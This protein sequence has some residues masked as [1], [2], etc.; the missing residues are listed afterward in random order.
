VEDLLVETG[1]DVSI[2]EDTEPAKDIVPDKIGLESPLE[3]VAGSVYKAVYLAEQIYGEMPAAEK[4]L[5]HVMKLQESKGGDSAHLVAVAHEINQLTRIHRAYLN[6]HSRVKRTVVLLTDETVRLAYHLAK[7]DGVKFVVYRYAA[8]TYAMLGCY[9]RAAA[10]VELAMKLNPNRKAA[11]ED[12]KKL[13]K[14]AG[15]PGLKVFVRGQ[16]PN[17]DVR[18]VIQNGR[19]LV[20]I[21]AISET[22]GAKVDFNAKQQMVIVNNG[23]INVNLYLNNKI[24][25]VN[26][27]KV[28]LDEPAKVINKRTMIP[29]RF[30]SENLG[31]AVE[32]DPQSQTITVE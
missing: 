26:G 1:E 16:R 5:A 9:K 21:R 23:N 19:T 20:P 18:P 32:Y 27:K 10:V 11:Y 15:I 14:K 28:V 24:A 13:Y 7:R 17:F 6:S 3:P 4:L 29:L 12:L 8:S 30:V 2:L 25:L 31:A 22:M